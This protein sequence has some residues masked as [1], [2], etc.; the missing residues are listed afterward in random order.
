[1]GQNLTRVLLVEDQ[2]SDYLLTRAMLSRSQ[3]Q[4]FELTWADSWQAGM[5]AIRRCAHDVCLLDFR[6][7]GGDGLE[8]LKESR[9]IGCRAPVILL[10]G[11]A[12]YK[13]DV[14][15]MELGA[16]DFLVKD[17]LTPELLER[18]I[19]YSLAH[20]VASEELRRRQ[21]SLSASELRFRS[22]V[23]SAGEAIVLSDDH[24]RILF[25]NKSA[26]KVFGFT[27]DDIVGASVDSLFPE[28]YRD[29]HIDGF[30][31][32]SSF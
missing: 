29:S 17:T 11:I 8:L 16:A 27:D 26:E 28:S 6:I 25:W 4:V 15:A 14:E 9:D 20:A 13:L 18:S 24:G 23:Q 1:M 10:T 31:V 12:D 2:E 7:G 19:R 22:V 5:E 3:N 32:F 30:E 21:E